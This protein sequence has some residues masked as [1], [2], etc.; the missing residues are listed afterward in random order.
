MP[1]FFKPV[2]PTAYTDALSY[3]EMIGQLTE[4]INECVDGINSIRDD[5][6]AQLEAFK[7]TIDAELTEQRTYVDQKEKELEAYTDG[8]IAEINEASE[9]FKQATQDDFDEKFRYLTQLVNTSLANYKKEIQQ[10]FTNFQAQINSQF[11]AFSD[12]QIQARAD[13]E[14]LIRGEIARLEEMIRALEYELPDIFDP[15]LPGYDTVTRVVSRVWEADRY[16]GAITA[17]DFDNTAHTAKELDDGFFHKGNLFSKPTTAGFFDQRSGVLLNQRSPY[18]VRNPYT[19]RY[20]LLGD[21]V[22]KLFDSV[23]DTATNCLPVSWYDTNSLTA[24]SFDTAEIPAFRFDTDSKVY[25]EEL[26]V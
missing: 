7:Q 11:S 9:Q 3:M 13:F 16:P 23:F 18:F 2:L 5:V 6:T 12:E 24:G 17:M 4:I 1:C 26:I 19:G 15:T 21:V 25:V 22:E 8:K 20:R 14:S 10:L